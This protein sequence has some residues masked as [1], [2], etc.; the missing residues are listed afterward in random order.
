M[1]VH[2]PVTGSVVMSSLISLKWRDLTLDGAPMTFMGVVALASPVKCRAG[3][4]M[5]TVL[6]R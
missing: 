5:Y 4:S 2:S 6:T 1:D 3:P